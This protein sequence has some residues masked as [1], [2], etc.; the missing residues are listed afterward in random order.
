MLSGEWVIRWFECLGGLSLFLQCL[1]YA[2]LTPCTDPSGVWSWPVQR[3][4]IPDEPG[5]LK[6]L[7]DWLYQPRVY[8][9]QLAV[10]TLASLALMVLGNH[11][12]IATVLFIGDRKSTRLN[13][14][15]VSESR[16]PSSA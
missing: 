11:V 14:S 10:R 5:W 2:R 8:K 15:H 9:A 13:S 12:V 6:R 1:E 16:M 4:D 7:L 3:A